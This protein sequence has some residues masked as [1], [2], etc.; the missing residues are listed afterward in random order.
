MSNL[1]QLALTL[2]K[3]LFK[4]LFADQR[5]RSEA[6][7]M[8]AIYHELAQTSYQHRKAGGDQRQNRNPAA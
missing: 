5:R 3:I 6:I 2:P 1:C 4:N 8:E 7:D